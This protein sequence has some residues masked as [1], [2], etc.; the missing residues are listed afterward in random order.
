[1]S[2]PPEFRF[3]HNIQDG[4]FRYLP[5][6]EENTAN[7]HFVVKL[8][9]NPSDED[10]KR[11]DNEIPTPKI[12]IHPHIVRLKE[13][14]PKENMHAIVMELGGQSLTQLVSSHNERGVLVDCHIVYQ[15]MVDISSALCFMHNHETE[16]TAHGD[17]KLENILLF[18]D[19]RAKLCDL[20]AAESDDLNETGGVPSIQYVSPERM[21]DPTCRASASADVWALGIV[22]HWLL[23]GKPPFTSESSIRLLRDIGKFKPSQIGT[24]CGEKE[25]ELLI[26][27]LDPDCGSRL[28]SKQ[29]VESKILRCL[30]N[31][32]KAGW[33]LSEMRSRETEKRVGDLEATLRESEAKVA[34][35]QHHLKSVVDGNNPP[36]RRTI[37]S[38]SLF[39]TLA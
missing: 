25:R 11:T 15:V 13:V 24:S 1:M 30:I 35:L 39:R 14:V 12:F 34:E 36:L 3:I 29:L 7:E 2:A 21:E 38:Q 18:G 4:G 17:V 5:K 16:R 32:T 22:L 23:F 27:M 8:V 33:K 37:R 31:T 10:L 26:R 9:R 19:G 20:G 6:V 28:T